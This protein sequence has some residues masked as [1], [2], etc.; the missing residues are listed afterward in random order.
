MKIKNNLL[1]M[2][3][4]LI[5]GIGVG[6]PVTLICMLCFGALDATLRQ[7]LIWTAA[8]G[9]CGLV[10]WFLFKINMHLLLW[11]GLHFLLC[12][13]IAAAAVTLC[14]YFNDMTS[15]LRVCLPMFAGIYFV[16]YGVFMLRAKIDEKRMNEALQTDLNKK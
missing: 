10:S 8:S 2:I 12:F 14:G 1:G 11:T 3:D 16:L 6:V 9:L 5:L 7:V 13:G 4:S 15:F